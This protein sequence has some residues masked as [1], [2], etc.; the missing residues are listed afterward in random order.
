VHSSTGVKLPVAD[1]AEAVRSRAPGALLCLD[2]VHGFGAEADRPR[3]L[4]CDVLFSG[5]HKWLSGPRGTGLV[6]ARADAWERIDA[7]VPS[8]AAP[9]Y[10][11][12]L[13]GEAVP[14]TPAGP[15][16]TP[17]GFHA[18]EHRW[19][20]AEAFGFQRAIGTER[21]ADRIHD[22]AERLKAGLAA[23]PGVTL[24]TPRSGALSSGLVCLDLRGRRAPQVVDALAER[25][26]VA[27]VTPYAVEHVRLGVGVHLSDDDVD[28]AVRA[29]GA[30]A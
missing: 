25:G 10:G 16:H 22:L 8:F 28:A 21:I 17:G 26:V 3:D 30:L 19:A 5:C 6:W 1:I 14:A 29:V 20:L 15:V 9:A 13:R 23:H 24:V 27:S 7:L 2:A 11:A 18:F 4:G 12:W